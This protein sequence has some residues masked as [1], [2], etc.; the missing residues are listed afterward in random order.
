MALLIFG[1]FRGDNSTRIISW[2]SVLVLFVTSLLILIGPMDGS[3]TFAQMFIVDRFGA[4]LK[5][6]ILIGSISTIFLSFRYL[7][8]E[9][10]E[11][12]EFPILILF[13]TLGMLMMVSASDLIALY[14]G[15]ELQS[16]SLYILAAFKRDSATST[17]SGL[18]YFVLGALASGIILYG[19]SLVYG[20]SGTTNFSHISEHLFNS[21]VEIGFLLGVAFLIAGLAFKVSAVPFHMWTPDVYQGAPTPVTAFFSIAPKMSKTRWIM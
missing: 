16:L 12:F 4:Y 13:A 2:A 5:I 15:L 6:L 19:S 20:Y 3:Q 1:V 18:K 9:S 7:R 8:F 10:I 17:E 14:L 21:Q 11:R